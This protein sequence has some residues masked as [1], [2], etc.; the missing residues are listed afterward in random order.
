MEIDE[1]VHQADDGKDHPAVGVAIW[2]GGLVIHSALQEKGDGVF[3]LAFVVFEQLQLHI[4]GNY[5]STHYP[6][7][8]GSIAISGSS[9]PDI[10]LVS[11]FLSSIA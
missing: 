6:R 5:H 4:G 3:L 11:W 1:K 2:I 10:R 7:T 8:D 9:S